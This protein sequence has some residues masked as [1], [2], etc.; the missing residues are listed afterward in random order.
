L[1]DNL[2][3]ISYTL[4]PFSEVEQ[5]EFLKKFWLRNSNPEHK[6]EHRLQIYATALIRKLAQSISDK[7]REFTGIPLQM[8]MLAEAFEQEFRS[9]YVSEKSEP[10]LPQKLDLVELYGRFIDSKYDIFF[11]EK[12]KLQPGNIGADKI[13]EGYLK[14]IQ[15]EHQLLALEALFIEDQVTFLQSYDRTTFSN[16]DL[17]RI[18]IAQRNNEGRPHFIHRTFAEYFVADFLIKQLTKKTKQHVQVKGILLSEVLVK[19]DCRVI[20]AFMDGM[21]KNSK[22]SKE[23][24]NEYGGL[25]NEDLPIFYTDGLFVAEEEDNARI[26][27]FLLDSLKSRQHSNE[28][29][30]IRRSS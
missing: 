28:G 30:G 21:L 4:Q 9:F 24:L 7:D 17:A 10:E 23:A 18:G 12:S 3:Q 16:E 1:E 20:R 19:E 27:G 2:H 8:R 22:P 11:K 15:V 6:D 5:V 26:I 14:N 29:G 13:R 25:L